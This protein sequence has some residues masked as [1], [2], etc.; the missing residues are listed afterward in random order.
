MICPVGFTRNLEFLAFKKAINHPSALEF[1]MNL[2]ERCQTE[3]KCDLFLP[4][5]YIAPALALPADLDPLTVKTALIQFGMVSPIE[6][7]PDWYQ[8]DFFEEQNAELIARWKNGRKGGR[9]KLAK[10]VQG[11]DLPA[12]KPAQVAPAL[13]PPQPADEDVPF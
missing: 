13:Q 8:I 9:P 12:A 3:K 10:P 1:L 4:D 11:D 5:A 6:G 7:S 2:A